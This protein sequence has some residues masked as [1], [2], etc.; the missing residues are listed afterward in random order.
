MEH[1]D[2]IFQVKKK[3]K[4]KIIIN[5]TSLCYNL[6]LNTYLHFSMSISKKQSD[7]YFP[8]FQFG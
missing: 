4:K 8:V 1:E 7:E 2:Y 5:K 3:Y 6:V